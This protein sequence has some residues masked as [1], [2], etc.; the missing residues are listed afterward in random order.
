MEDVEALQIGPKE[1]VAERKK[2]AESFKHKPIIITIYSGTIRRTGKSTIAANLAAYISL[3]TSVLLVDLD[4]TSSLLHGV[5]LAP[6]EVGVLQAWL[7][8]LSP[9]VKPSA[10]VPRVHVMPPGAAIVKRHVEVEPL[11]SIIWRYAPS[12]AIVDTPA[13]GIIGDLALRIGDLALIVLRNADGFEDIAKRAGKLLFE[14]R[15]IAVANM[16]TSP[17]ELDSPFPVFHLPYSR[18]V[19][20]YRD[21]FVAADP[22]TDDGKKWQNAF[23]NFAKELISIYLSTRLS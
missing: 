4:G 17:I 23:A 3:Y 13:D 22:K 21:V 11:R 6:G 9:N 8:G 7:A 12:L 14:R 19:S 15:T 2:R 16:E 1:D 18:E 5:W 20:E 10:K